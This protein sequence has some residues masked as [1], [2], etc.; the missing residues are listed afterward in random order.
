MG[1]YATV[2]YATV[3]P[4]TLDYIMDDR[5]LSGNTVKTI[6]QKYSENYWQHERTD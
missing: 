2:E 3:I 5:S 4:S 6:K 1:H